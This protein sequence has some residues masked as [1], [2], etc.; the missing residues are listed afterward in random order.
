MRKDR[1]E[2][3]KGDIV[4]SQKQDFDTLQKKYADGEIDD[5]EYEQGIENLLQGGD[6]FMD[7]EETAADTAKDAGRSLKRKLAYYSLPLT[8]L[9]AFAIPILVPGISPMLAIVAAP[10]ILTVALI[11]WGYFKVRSIVK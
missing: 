3:L 2:K 8:V 5:E 7:Y 1:G 9:L 10:T 4:R 11:V 6:E